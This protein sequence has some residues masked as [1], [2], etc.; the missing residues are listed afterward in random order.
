MA[1]R[2]FQP[3]KKKHRLNR[4]QLENMPEAAFQMA[5]EAAEVFEVKQN[6]QVSPTNESQE[7]K[8]SA[9]NQG[10]RGTG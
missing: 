5:L 4:E 1:I 8:L 9:L 7:Q 6:E 2:T 3:L 10:H